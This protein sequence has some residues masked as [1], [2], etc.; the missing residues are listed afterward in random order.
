MAV[1][2]KFQKYVIIKSDEQIYCTL[3]GLVK[4][5]G[6]MC[7]AHEQYYLL[8]TNNISFFCNNVN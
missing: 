5:N 1:I 3:K 4:G 8:Q 7:N 6:N 2:S